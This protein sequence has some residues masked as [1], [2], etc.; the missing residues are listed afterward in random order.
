MHKRIISLCV[1]ISILLTSI[2]ARIGYIMLSGSYTVEAGYNSFSLN[3]DNLNYQLNYRN[4]EKLTN[5]VKSY[6]AIIKPNEKC[7]GELYKYFNYPQIKSITEELSKGYPVKVE[8]DK[9]IDSKYIQVF[10]TYK[11]NYPC[12][13]LINKSSSGI[14]SYIEKPSNG[15][16]INFSVDAKGRLL[17]GDNGTIL[18]DNSLNKSLTLTIDKNIQDIANFACEVMNNGCCI[19]M[20]VKTSE[21]LAVVNKPDDTYINKCFK[22]YPVGSVFKIIVSACAL[23]NNEKLIYN[24][25]GSITVG[26]S[27]FSCQNN[28]RHGYQTLKSAL[29]NSCNCYFVNL[30]LNLGEEKLLETAKKLGFDSQ[31]NL[32]N[33]WNVIASTL[34]SIESLK[35]KGQLAL[36]GFG[37]GS[38]LSSPLQVCSA[39]CTIGNNGNRIEPSIVIDTK[40]ST[41]VISEETSKTLVKYMRYVVQNGTGRNADDI[42]HLSAGKTATAQTGQFI[43]SNEILNTWFAGL[44]PYNNPKYAIVVMTENG[45]SGSAD[46]CP[47]FRTIVENIKK[48]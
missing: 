28:K 32:Y 41:S 37:Q 11:S 25:N 24:C 18:K 17:S 43:G 26:D 23:E 27:T 9:K 21:I 13:Q 12:R 19:V 42:K 5:N 6:V 4:G 14:L 16:K 7:V 48:L 40:N 30:A 35:S 45:T 44:Y 39:L 8:I 20:D 10:E 34:P 31:I 29:A 33:N 36:F 3:I 47:I 46:C 22:N 38:L 15:R 1:V 2:T